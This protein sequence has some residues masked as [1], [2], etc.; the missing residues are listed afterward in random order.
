[1]IEVLAYNA[2]Y[3]TGVAV[4]SYNAFTPAQRLAGYRWLQGEYAA[5]RRVRPPMCD[6]CGQTE[7]IIEA[8]SEDYSRPY[9]AHIGQYG[10]CYTCHMMLHCQF[11]SPEPWQQ[12]RAALRAGAVFKPFHGRAF[13]VFAG[14]FLRPGLP[15]PARWR[16]PMRETVLDAIEARRPA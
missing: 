7:G 4:K 15:T 12:Y 13:H 2:G 9:G 5:G 8:H 16:P 14:W 11:T 1:M 3:Y 6:A 10:L